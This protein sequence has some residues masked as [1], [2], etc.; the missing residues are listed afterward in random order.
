MKIVLLTN[1][2]QFHQKSVDSGSG[3]LKSL[4]FAANAGLITT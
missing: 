2:F 3:N 4:N 1:I